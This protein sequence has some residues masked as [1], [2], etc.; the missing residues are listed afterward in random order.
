MLVS[1]SCG[2]LIVR[3]SVLVDVLP[4]DMNFIATT[5][6]RDNDEIIKISQEIKAKK[7][8]MKAK[9]SLLGKK[10]SLFQQEK[11]E[12]RNAKTYYEYDWD[13]NRKRLMCVMEEGDTR[14]VIEESISDSD[15]QMRFDFEE[16][17]IER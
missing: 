15:R 7:E 16:K 1:I 11:L 4:S 17:N 2:E 10:I 12:V 8:E 3:D 13:N 5:M 14:K 6:K 9:Q